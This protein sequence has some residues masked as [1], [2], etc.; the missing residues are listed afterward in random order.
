MNTF[1]FLFSNTMLVISAGTH[2]MLVRIV[3]RE[4]PDQT[5]LDFKKQSDL[6]LHCLSLPFW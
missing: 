1:P 3:N 4:D 2:E 6:G 5:A